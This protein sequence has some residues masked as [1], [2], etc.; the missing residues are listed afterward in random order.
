MGDPIETNTL[1]QF[2]TK[3]K[4][5]GA[6]KIP[7]GS[8]KTNIGHLESAAGV[9][10]LIKILLMMKHGVFVPSL[11]ANELNPKIEFSKYGIAVSTSVTKWLPDSK[12]ERLSCINSFGFGGTNSHAIVKQIPNDRSSSLYTRSE[13]TNAKKK[14]IVVVSA[15]DSNSLK[16]TISNFCQC[17]QNSTYELPSLSYTTAMRRDHFRFRT[18]FVADSVRKL[19][20]SLEMKLLSLEDVQPVP[21][22]TSP[23]IFVFCGVGTAWNGMC[24]DL[25]SEFSVFRNAV[26]EVDR[27][28]F[29]MTNWSIM[30]IL[31]QKKHILDNPMVNHIAIFTCQIG[32]FRL[33]NSFGI[34]PQAVV[35]Q[36][37]GEVAAACASGSLP[38][39][40]AVKVI[41]VRSKLLASAVGGQMTVIRGVDTGV[42]ENTC[43]TIT[44]GKVVIAVYI[45]QDCCTVSGDMKAV[46]ELKLKLEKD[47]PITCRDLGVKCAYHSHFT[48]DAGNRL[49]TELNGFKPSTPK[50]S[51]FSSVTGGKITT[52]E[53]ATTKFWASNVKDPVRFQQAVFESTSLGEDLV[54]IEIGP[55]P[56]LRP[57]LS[58]IVPDKRT[59]IFPSMTKSQ[60]SQTVY[61]ALGEIYTQGYELS[62]CNI[63]DQSAGLTDIPRY[64]FNKSV[65][66]EES[67]KRSVKRKLNLDNSVRNTSTIEPVPRTSNEFSVQVNEQKTDYIFEHFVEGS[68]IIPGALYGNIGL[69]VGKSMLNV[70]TD[71]CVSWSI[72]NPLALVHGQNTVLNVQCKQVATAV[73]YSVFDD[74]RTLLSTGTTTQVQHKRSLVDIEA[75]VSVLNEKP[76]DEFVYITLR[77]IGIAHGP[78]YQIVNRGLYSKDECFAEVLL[79]GK[80]LQMQSSTALHP[81]IIDGMLQCSCSFMSFYDLPDNFKLLPIRIG[82]LVVKQRV[83]KRMFIFAKLMKHTSTKLTCNVVLL[84]E[85]GVVVAEMENIETRILNER[86]DPE[87]LLYNYQWEELNRTEYRPLKETNSSAG[88][89]VVVSWN[90]SKCSCLSAELEGKEIFLDNTLAIEHV[91]QT[92]DEIE[93]PSP[94][95]VIT[96]GFFQNI[97]D[98]DGHVIYRNILS[99][100]KTML[101]LIKKYADTKSNM[102]VVTECTQ[103]NDLVSNRIN[104][105]GAELWGIGRSVMMEPI[106]ISINLI[107]VFP[108]IEDNIDSLKSVISAIR[109]KNVEFPQEILIIRNKVLFGSIH[110]GN[111]P[112]SV[113]I[114]KQIGIP[115]S[116]TSSESTR[117]QH[118]ACN[119]VQKG[120]QRSIA[121]MENVEVLM[122]CKNPLTISSQEGIQSQEKLPTTGEIWNSKSDNLKN[123]HVVERIGKVLSSTKKGKHN[124]DV[125][126]CFPGILQDIVKIPQ[127][128]ICKRSDFA[129]YKPG[130]LQ[131]AIIAIHI[132]DLVKAH[133]SVLGIS[134][135]QNA[136]SLTILGSILKPKNTYF[137]H[138]SSLNQIH[139]LSD[140]VSCILVLSELQWVDLQP[141]M[142]FMGNTSTLI[143]LQSTA[144]SI[145]EGCVTFSVIRLTS[146]DVFEVQHLNQRFRCAQKLLKALEKKKITTTIAVN[147]VTILP[148]EI[149]E[150]ATTGE[151]MA[152]QIVK[153]RCSYVVVGG[154]TGLGWLIVKGLAQAS[155]EKIFILSRQKPNRHTTIRIGNVES[156]HST[157]IIPLQ[158]DICDFASLQEKFH[159][160]KSQ[161]HHCP[162][163]G[164]FHGAAT[165]ADN[166]AIGMD[167]DQF[168]RPLQPKILG[169]LNL[170]QVSRDLD[171]D[172]FVMHSSI[173]SLLGNSGQCNYA[174]GNAFQ[175][176]MAI[177]RRSIG[178]PAQSIRWGALGVGL[179]T[180]SFTKESLKMKGFHPIPASQIFECLSDVLQSNVALPVIAHIN[181]I[182]FKKL[183][184][185]PQSRK[186][187]VFLSDAEKVSEIEVADKLD[188]AHEVDTDE[189]TEAVSS[190]VASVFAV[191]HT[192]IQVDFPIINFGLDSQKG[193]ELASLMFAKTH[194]RVPYIYLATNNHTIRD[195]SRYIKE[196]QNSNMTDEDKGPKNLATGKFTTHWDHYALELLKGESFI[197]YREVALNTEFSKEHTYRLQEA[198]QHLV[199]LHPDIRT[200]YTLVTD[201][202]GNDVLHKEVIN[203]EEAVLPFECVENILRNF[204][205]RKVNDAPLRVVCGESEQKLVIKL[206]FCPLTFDMQSIATIIDCAMLLFILYERKA[207]AAKMSEILT[208]SFPDRYPKYEELLKFDD[209][210]MKTSW[211]KALAAREQE[212]TS[213]VLTS[214][215]KRLVEDRILPELLTRALRQHIDS[216]SMTLYQLVCCL[217]HLAFYYVT[218]SS[219]VTFLA[220]TDMR[221]YLGIP[222]KTIGMYSNTVPVSKMF[223]KWEKVSFA[224]YVKETTSSF[225]CT[226]AS[227]AYPFPK[228]KSLENFDAAIH[229]TL[230][231]SFLDLSNQEYEDQNL[232]SVSSFTPGFTSIAEIEL[233]TLL[234]STNLQFKMRFKRGSTMEE[235]GRK[236]L[237]VLVQLTE[238]YLMNP[239]DDLEELLHGLHIGPSRTAGDTGIKYLIDN[240]Q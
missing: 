112:R 33:W 200:Q 198:L 45:S 213:G 211:N 122:S 233:A 37:V 9:V 31:Q 72:K 49:Q 44:Q 134:D 73:E 229:Q 82:S 114:S 225:S 25:I 133:R 65:N 110:R 34:Y 141:Y 227:M 220:Q 106:K 21:L 63:V 64:V 23:I 239:D 218:D 38:L 167:M 165:T 184:I 216:E 177:F 219:H 75:R 217:L 50:I 90:K 95:I 185:N 59:K 118:T 157:Q 195:V 231:C 51:V 214:T 14:H 235:Y 121:V 6:D 61:E 17:L 176:A 125:I 137:K 149:T 100:G 26:T 146:A 42:V 128:L 170:H 223:W 113:P 36:S 7:I 28:L 132:A 199:K 18:Y 168:E 97:A 210:K 203:V 93:D 194:V 190:C 105:H 78:I 55:S 124:P 221:R 148:G 159:L 4:K 131:S 171:L 222:S 89:V 153:S 46:S 232:H 152:E 215:S 94:C 76:S 83:K 88:H 161:T 47:H 13:H 180:D 197:E 154:L 207:N 32:L 85:D 62:W 8:V 187:H 158:V 188:S 74:T 163:K 20:S 204:T 48:N 40:Q 2:F 80:H 127:E 57:H 129:D 191:H 120:K 164:I 60:G 123:A 201:D 175:D 117:K 186:F 160:M 98:F 224:E 77:N 111:G 156:L 240:I 52:C 181:W 68:I 102:I 84:Q 238:K 5:L 35:G 179:A 53:Y 230:L 15:N 178:L 54:F 162:I 87:T 16:K 99:S 144:E 109:Q 79:T 3:Y 115:L 208:T 139:Q 107:D 19:K 24:A 234:T 27:I 173:A 142:H 172:H 226:K 237:D 136:A 193:T 138:I 39:E 96:P 29:P 174:A 12:G 10:G 130:L 56:V 182:T 91:K 236:V 183:D 151:N 67:S 126:C 116:E 101:C 108:S 140:S 30:E 92:F 1:G 71:I 103:E 192:Q 135:D 169:T 196:M 150:E 143:C 81:V 43:K 66:F 70:E 155:T 11:H 228:I 212:R 58:N 86:I 69:E 104:L 22:Q 206:L 145:P 202:I 205:L 147:A 189:I 209:E 41:F 119:Y 166:F